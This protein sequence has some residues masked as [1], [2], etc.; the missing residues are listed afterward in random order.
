[1]R[2]TRGVTAAEYAILAVGVVIIVGG[3]VLG[4]SPYLV[5]AFSDAGTVLTSTQ[6]SLPAAA[7]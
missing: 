7:R 6:A 5:N 2:D 4:F 1:M 3:A